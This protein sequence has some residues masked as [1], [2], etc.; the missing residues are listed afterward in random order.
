MVWQIPHGEAPDNIRN[1][2]LLEGQD[3][4]R[5]GW[6]GRVGLLITKNL[7]VA[8]ESGTYTTDT[9]ET[10]AMLRA[11]DK[12]TGNEVGAV[13]MTAPQTGSPMTYAVDDQQS[14][15]YTHLTLPTILLV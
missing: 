1:H 10:G 5:T 2:P 9:G 15:S 12:T 13:Y 4:G 11:Y 6:P 7:V 14:V 3:I 8:G